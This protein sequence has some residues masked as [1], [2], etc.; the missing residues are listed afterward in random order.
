[1]AL[2]YKSLN[3]GPKHYTKVNSL[4]K[5]EERKEP[6]RGIGR[7]GLGTVQSYSIATVGL[8]V[9]FITRMTITSNP[10]PFESERGYY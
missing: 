5:S 6:W 8:D 10:G 1:M 9:E 3:E 2:S 7:G 4:R